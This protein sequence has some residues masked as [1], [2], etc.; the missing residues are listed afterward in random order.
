M[1]NNHIA[2]PIEIGI[3]RLSSANPNDTFSI[4]APNPV[5]TIPII[6]SE[7]MY[8]IL[9]D[10]KT[11]TIPLR[12]KAKVPSRLLKRNLCFPKRRPIKAANVSLMIK[13]ANEVT[14]ITFGKIRTQMKA[15]SK[16]Y[17]APVRVR[18]L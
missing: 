5:L 6:Y 7:K 14:T 3:T 15:E 11:T 13:I 8:S 1:Y 18:F 12:K 16:T 2:N 10:S 9:G 4:I 17:V